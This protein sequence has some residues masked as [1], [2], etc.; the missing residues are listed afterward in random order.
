MLGAGLH[1]ERVRQRGERDRQQGHEDEPDED[2]GEGR[3]QAHEQGGEDQEHRLEDDDR[4][5]PRHPAE[6]EGKAAHGSDAEAA[7]RE[8]AGAAPGDPLPTLIAGQINRVHRTVT[9]VTGREMLA[10]CNPG[11]VSREVLLLLDGM[12][13]LLSEK[14]LNYAVR[15]PE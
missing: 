6:E 3:P 9:A 8:E 7:P 4:R 14:V 5:V 12:E 1:G 11:E 15:P 13:G 10:G 2:A